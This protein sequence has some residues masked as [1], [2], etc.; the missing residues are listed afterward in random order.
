MSRT[1]LRAIEL[2][3]A[4]SL[5]LGVLP[6]SATGVDLWRDGDRFVEASGSLREFATVTNGTDGPRFVESLLENGCLGDPARFRDCPAFDLVGDRD[7]WT[8]LTRLRLQ[9][10][11][12]FGDGWSGQLFYDFEWRA[13]ILDGLFAAPGAVEDTFLGLEDR[14]GEATDRHAQVHRVYRGWLRFEQG[15]LQV[16]IGRQRIPWGVGRLWNPIDRFNAIGPLALEGDQSLGID[17]VDVRWSFSGFNQLQ[18]LYAPGTRSADARYAA[19]FEAVI[20]DV[21][22]GVM[23]GRFE[24]AFAAGF[25][26]AG[27]LGD[28][29]WR[30]EAV[31]TNPSRSV[32]ELGG[33]PR[34]LDP[35]WQLVA[36]IDH[37]FDVGTGIYVLIEHLWDQNA[38]G[39]G[40]GGRG[41]E[42]LPFFQAPGLP[43]SA[44]RFGGSRVISLVSHQTG[45]M[46]GYELTSALSGNLLVL[47]D[48]R[49]E[50]AAVAPIVT[51]TGF[52]TVELSVGAQL[53]AGGRRSQYGGQ[54][55]LAYAQVE[56]FF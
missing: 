6:E 55:A 20:R 54:E 41:A 11:A 9:L 32:L 18:L 26:L 22:V 45:L 28:S 34:E 51:F 4:L 31:W 47:W 7:T 44:D 8:S 30:L 5:G 27:N 53:F 46:V 25:D 16:T 52:N 15:P 24:Q 48:W 13:G 37:N 17:A 3:L 43:I 49:G 39:L 38:L 10:D 40:P 23:V 29:A 21:D 35:F 42:L 2:A 14:V 36:S 1:P 50:S 33:R 12:A 56:W 19:R